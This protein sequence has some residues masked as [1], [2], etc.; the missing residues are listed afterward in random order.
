MPEP[1]FLPDFWYDAV[2]TTVTIPRHLANRGDLVTITR[3]DYEEL[4]AGRRKA[5][6]VKIFKPTPRDVRI[7]ARGRKEFAEGKFISASEL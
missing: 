7:L 6:K 3:S 5:E 1:F 4:L 2:M